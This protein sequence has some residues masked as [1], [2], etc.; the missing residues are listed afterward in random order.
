MRAR[1]IAS[2]SHLRVPRPHL[3]DARPGVTLL[4]CAALLLSGLPLRVLN[5][6]ETGR[7]TGASGLADAVQN[8]T[9]RVS[10]TS[11]GAE[12]NA[13]SYTWAGDGRPTR[14]VS[15]DGRYL[16]FWSTATNLPG[17]AGYYVRDT[18]LGTT[19]PAAVTQAGGNGSGTYAAMSGDGRYVAFASGSPDIVPGDTNGVADIFVR[20]LSMATTVR[21]SVDSSGNQASA[22]SSAPY[23]SRDG[24]YVVF[25]SDANLGG[26]AP[27]G[28][29]YLRD[30]SLGTTDF[31]SIGRDGAVAD[32]FCDQPSVS[33][34]GRYVSFTS[35]AS[36]LSAIPKNN[37][38]ITWDVY[39]RDRTAGTTVR[40]SVGPGG[41]QGNGQSNTAMLTGDGRSVL[42][43]SGAGNLIPP[44]STFP[45]NLFLR[46]LDANTTTRIVENADGGSISP[47]GRYIVFQSALSNLVPGDTNGS[48]DIFLRDQQEGSTQLISQSSSGVIG[49][50]ESQWPSVSA[51]GRFVAF[52][53]GATNLVTGDTN[54]FSDV[55]LRDRG[56]VDVGAAAPYTYGDDPNGAYT[57]EGVNIGTGVYTTAAVDLALPGR[58]LPF[59]FTRS[60][61]SS[62]AT[63][64]PLGPAWSYSF[65]WKV[66]DAGGYLT[67]RRGDGQRD[68]FTRNADGTYA[69]PPNVFDTLIKNGDGTF[70][71]TLKNQI[72][73]EFSTIGQL[74]RVHEPAGN[75]ISLTYTSGNL[76]SITDSVG[77][78]VTLGYDTSNRIT[79]LQDPLGRKVTYAY[80]ANGRLA[81]VTDKIGNAAGQVATQHQWKYAYDGTTQ[82]LTTLTDP[83]NRVRI[84]NTYDA[85]G[86]VYQQRDGLSQLT[87]ITYNSG[88]T[89]TVDARGNSSAQSYDDR[90]RALIDTRVV[91]GQTLTLT[92]VYDPSG[93]LTSV[94]DRNNQTT[95]YTYDTRGNVLTKTDPQVDQQT[96]RYLTQFTYDGKNNP[97]QV[98]DPRTFVTTNAYDATTNVLLSVTS[99]IDATTNAVT[100]YEYS[101]AANKGMPTRIVAPRGNIN[102]TPDY[103]YATNLTYDTQGNLVTRIDPDA[104]K[105]TL[106]YDGA[107]RQTSRVDP[108]GYAVGA[109]AADHTWVTTFNENDQVKTE[110]NPLGSVLAHA[111]DGAGDQQSTTDRNGNVSTYTYDNNARLATVQQKPDPVGNPTLIY[112]TQVGRD[113]NGNALHVT[114]ANGVVTDYGY[115]DLDRML[116]YSTHPNV[117]TTLTTALVL[118][119]NGNVLTKTTPAP[120]LQ[121]TTNSYDVLS[122]L[123]STAASGLTTISYQY[124]GSGNRT[125]MTDGTGVTSYQFDGLGRMI[126]AAQPN[127]TLSYTYD[128]D[129]NRTTMAYP[130]GADTVTYTFTSGGRL[131]HLTDASARTSTY[132]YTASGLVKT[133]LA[134][135]NLQTTYSYDRAQRLT[136]V[137][138]AVGTTTRTRHAYT[139]DAEG[140][141]VALDE[142]VEGITT[143][144]STTWSAS[145]KVNSDTG[146]TVQDHPAI[147]LGADGAHYLIWDDARDG[148]ANIYFSKRDAVT[149]VWSSPNTKVNNDTGTRIQVNPAISTDSGNN[150]YAVWEDSRDGANNKIDTNIYSSKRTSSNGTWSANG[151]VNDDA[152]S[153]P[154]QRNPRIAGSTAGLETAVWVDLRATQNNIYS[155]QLTTPGGTTWGAN[156]KVT[157]NTAALKDFPD[158]A[159]GADG[160]AYA[161]W[162]DSRN[163]NVDIYFS[164]LAPGASAWTANAKISDDPG[165][166][167]QTNAR[168]GVDATGN[169]T[170]IWLDARTS[171]AK[172]RMSRLV[173]GSAT[174]SASSI[175]T[176]AAARPLST[177]LS[178]RA[179][180]K[181][182]VAFHDNRAASTD[183]YGTEYD[184]WLNTW[185]TSSLVSDDPGAT[186]QQSPTVAYGTGEIAAAWRDDRAGNADIRARRAALMGTDHFGYSYDGLERLTAGTTT[187]PESFTLDAGSNIASRTGPSATYSYDAA[188]RLTGDGTQTF[189]WTPS[190]RL[191]NRGSDTFG[192]DALD[193]MT[194]S[195][196]AGTARSYAYD[197]T[198]LLQSRTQGTTTTFLWD[199]A[200]SPSRLLE[201]GGDRL[202]YGLGP[203]YVVKADGSTSAL[204]RD[205]GRSVRGELS[206]TG[207]VTASFRYRAYGAVAQSSGASNPTYLGYAS[208]LVDS[209]GL[210]YM[211]AR[212]YDPLI[213][214]FVSRD[215]ASLLASKPTS[216]SY[217]Y[218]AGNPLANI[219]PTGRWCLTL[220][221]GGIAAGGGL[222]GGQSMGAAG[223]VSF[224]GVICSSDRGQW[225]LGVVA[226]VG[227]FAGDR[228]AQN[229]ATGGAGNEAIGGFVGASPQLGVSPQA[230]SPADLGGPFRSDSV[231]VGLGI[232]GGIEH[233]TGSTGDGRSID[234]WNFGIPIPG[235]SPGLGVAVVSEDT[236]TMTA[237]LWSSER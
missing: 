134:P 186:A 41:V 70:T 197:G 162:Q 16:L 63:S 45:L 19:A 18:Q 232:G 132:A 226:T 96:P 48:P 94:T 42:F 106:G 73:Y 158:V 40:A 8:T 68:L 12:L 181:A 54:G 62:D 74:T 57:N 225:S 191:A 199:Q 146:T 164:K 76:T 189:T 78:A 99:Q 119:H 163:G 160:T 135:N 209:S 80:D 123:T 77:R 177:A 143:A 124:D 170:V 150:A 211:R 174:W 110:T 17:G 39:V 166:T 230:Q 151:K 98:T 144:P 85:T 32:M 58:L 31:I 121:V 81:T 168:I 192:Y 38:S 206:S 49:N 207:A 86:R 140:N 169:L 133:L 167:A 30:L 100:K 36:N 165:T 159:V 47:D 212:W 179:D 24:R 112:T 120:E 82:H 107:G 25:E 235:I 154:V 183:V 219:D 7:W 89:T 10:V 214:R 156:K 171:P 33:D 72:Q 220:G 205:G 233:Q 59:M 116:S 65:Y 75:Q 203:L 182:F 196:I 93:N 234:Y 26:P 52:W 109:S 115:D 125:Q 208:Q 46:D 172:I 102:P 175:V 71:L 15:D 126:Q 215:T 201:V 20:D 79:Q 4:L 213:G 11:A 37:Q 130:A 90:K 148:N 53:S 51:D 91:S 87:T 104:A 190:D 210:Y 67:L 176:D 228:H 224:G 97:T 141:R 204:A 35:R 127:G 105:T 193:R 221:Y 237:T 137:L 5:Y 153:N 84:T 142:F 157:D 22:A 50:S 195:T 95:D 194:G 13:A 136:L 187:N 131:D 34:D 66:S 113:A 139:L 155:A 216:N 200:T 138:N 88:A 117:S 55:F 69:A 161:V 129:G 227:G 145:V 222:F 147:A 229:A 28:G 9:V 44:D 180:G 178:V 61:N 108:D 64:G 173:A 231:N 111:Y 128:R 184:P 114:Q 92:H 29:I 185:A 152:T 188:N 83:D 217:L 1:K 2:P 236:G 6:V 60:Y 198:G 101:D 43:R 23:M 56:P 202:I 118:D 223:Q 103:I 218:A 14:T 122:R 3:R 149:G 21:V 27:G